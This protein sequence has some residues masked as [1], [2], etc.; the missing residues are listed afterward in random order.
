MPD[1]LIVE[2]GLVVV[3][4][5]EE[6][7]LERERAEKEAWDEW[8]RKALDRLRSAVDT[9]S[10]IRERGAYERRFE[11]GNQWPE[12]VRRMREEDPNGPRPCLTINRIP[13]FKRQ[14]L[15]ELRQMKPGIKVRPI[16][17][18]GDP[19][20]AEIYDGLIRAIE[21]NCNADS[22]Y[23]WAA[24]NCVSV[25]WGYWK[26]VTEYSG[27]G[28]ELDIKIKRIRNQWSVYLDPM[29]DET[30]GSDAMWGFLIQQI[31]KDQFE[32]MY[33]GKSS[34]IDIDRD[35]I[36]LEHWLGTDTVTVAEYWYLEHEITG[37]YV[38]LASGDEGTVSMDEYTRLQAMRGVVRAREVI[39]PVLYQA[40]ISGGDILEYPSRQPGRYV[41]IVEM[42]GVEEIVDGEVYFSG[43][44]RDAMDPQRQYNYTRSARVERTALEPKA[45]F[46]GYQGQFKSPKWKRANRYNYPYLE[47]SI[48][49]AWPGAQPLPLP[50]RSPG[51]QQSPGW[52]DE[53]LMSAQELKDVIGIHDPALGVQTP[54]VSGVAINARRS[55]SDTSHYHFADALGQA[56]RHTGRILVS[57]IPDVFPGTRAVEIVNGKGESERAVIGPAPLQ[58]QP[59][60]DLSIGSYDVTVDLGPSYATKRQESQSFM[61]ELARHNPKFADLTADW[62]VRMADV[63]GADELA[64]RFR[65]LL[66]PQILAAEN[67][68]VAAVAQQAQEQIQAL[69]GQIQQLLAALSSRE[70][71]QSLKEQDI[72]RRAIDDVRK[73]VEQMTKIEAEHAVNVP[74][75]AI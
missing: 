17:S 25:G 4:N 27:Q 47:A 11:L 10:E 24:D 23:T 58:G 34:G 21:R 69:Q 20:A 6:L 68:E 71:D 36:L 42:R 51:P 52:T 74:G 72:R 30:D 32:G 54:D 57:M 19:K 48:P 39:S 38:L 2:S 60:I 45:P 15:N 49:D 31:P 44:I 5:E 67:P 53:I 50:Q 33:P 26:I 28:F 61:L 18:D 40:I 3:A 55:E 59:A 37:M 46:I 65:T 9:D 70:R 1:D 12:D 75:S 14:I 29:R 62:L 16:D 7:E 35:S 56:L 8:H 22:A 73:H 64:R 66:P 41:P 13:A 63:I 43:I